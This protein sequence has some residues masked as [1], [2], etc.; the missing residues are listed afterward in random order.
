MKCG[1]DERTDF[2]KYRTLCSV[3]AR[4]CEKR[5]NKE[6]KQLL[7]LQAEIKRLEVKKTRLIAEIA[8]L[9][10]QKKAQSAVVS[11]SATQPNRTSSVNTSSTGYGQIQNVPESK[12]LEVVQKAFKEAFDKSIMN[13]RTVSIERVRE[14]LLEQ[15]F[16]IISFKDKEENPDNHL[17]YSNVHGVLNRNLFFKNNYH[18]NYY[19]VRNRKEEPWKYKRFRFAVEFLQEGKGNPTEIDALNRLIPLPLDVRM[20]DSRETVQKKLGLTDKMLPRD[21]RNIISPNI[22]VIKFEKAS[23]HLFFDNS[24]TLL[25]SY[26][27][28]F[29]N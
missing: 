9:E 2:V 8:D 16:R 12:R 15:E 17:Y 5:E 6:Y 11:A 20:G 19:E 22:I 3:S 24:T 14:K 23:Y 18:V 10:K 4:D 29:T 21:S 28:E 1:F 25:N 27:V 7:A 26:F 13:P